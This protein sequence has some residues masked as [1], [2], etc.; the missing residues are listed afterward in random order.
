MNT[1]NRPP[2]TADQIQSSLGSA[3]A[4]RNGVAAYVR[5]YRNGFAAGSR[6]TISD[7]TKWNS[8]QSSDAWDDGYLD[9][10]AGRER[11]HLTYCPT[12]DTTC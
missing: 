10:A 6:S 3:F 9:A 7:D 4:H 5:E 1:K 11:W 12:H 8:G 2:R